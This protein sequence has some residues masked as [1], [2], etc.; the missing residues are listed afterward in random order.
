M[1]RKGRTETKTL[2][3][4]IAFIRLLACVNPLMYI[5]IC[6]TCKGFSAIAAFIRLILMAIVRPQVTKKS[7][8]F[9]QSTF[10]TYYSCE[11]SPQCEFFAV[12]QGRPKWTD[13]CHRLGSLNAFLSARGVPLCVLPVTMNSFMSDECA[14]LSI[15]PLSKVAAELFYFGVNRQMISKS[16]LSSRG[17]VTLDAFKGSW[18]I[19][20]FFCRLHG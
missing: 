8:A 7:G 16:I 1:F 3:T 20:M 17:L 5:K 12:D 2:F 6:N 19:T 9:E 13:T 18:C 11:A 4:L 14:S 10:H 15:L